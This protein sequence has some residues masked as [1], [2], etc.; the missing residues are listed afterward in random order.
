[1]IKEPGQKKDNTKDRKRNAPTKLERGGHRDELDEAQGRKKAKRG[2]D[3]RR[4]LK[5][6]TRSRERN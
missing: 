2:E 6:P 3:L 1:M 5:R 4:D